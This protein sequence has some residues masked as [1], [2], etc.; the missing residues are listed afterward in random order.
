MS[1]HRASDVNVKNYVKGL[2]FSGFRGAHRGRCYQAILEVFFSFDSIFVCLHL[3]AS[4][5]LF[6]K[7]LKPSNFVSMR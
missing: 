6:F 5:F 1:N 4:P 2:N 7:T 3:H